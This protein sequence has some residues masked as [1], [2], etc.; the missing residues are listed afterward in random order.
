MSFV[1]CSEYYFYTEHPCYKDSQFLEV[2]KWKEE[3]LKRYLQ[4]KDSS[5]KQ[6]T[7]T[8]GWKILSYFPRGFLRERYLG[9]KAALQCR[10]TKQESGNPCRR[11]CWSRR[12]YCFVSIYSRLSCHKDSKAVCSKAAPQ[13]NWPHRAFLSC[14]S[15][16]GRVQ[17]QNP[18]DATEL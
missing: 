13:A 6:V 1:N 15:V 5:V 7:S 12:T 9:R 14:T 8:W 18:Q 4:E 17:Q 2:R 16:T 10:R 3:Q 11:H